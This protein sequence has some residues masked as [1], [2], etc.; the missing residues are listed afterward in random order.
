MQP[1]AVAEGMSFRLVPA[2]SRSPSSVN[3]EHRRVRARVDHA[4]A[5]MNIYTILRDFRQRGDDLHHAVQ[6]FAHRHNLALTAWLEGRD[7]RS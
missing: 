6:A 4:F 5:R 1:H 2:M 7:H 3:A